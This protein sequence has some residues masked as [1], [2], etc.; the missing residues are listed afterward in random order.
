METRTD[1]ALLQATPT[2]RAAFG[3]FY[4][5]HE[6]SLLGFFGA[7]TRRSELAADLTAETFASALESAGAFDPERGNARMWLFG[8]ARN[9]LAGSAR[10]GRVESRARDRLGLDA[11]VLEARQLELIDELVAREGDAIV[12]AWLADLPA[13]QAAALRERV[14]EGRSYAEIASE[15]RCSEA[16]VRQRVSRGLGR[17]RRR[18]SEGTG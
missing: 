9:V 7:L 4:E 6:R 5:R 11:L 15:L 1:D 10:R 14:L 18:L 3:V 17:L 8:I 16:V 2:D 12:A 13:D